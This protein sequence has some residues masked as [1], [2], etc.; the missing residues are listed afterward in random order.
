M[1]KPRP[2]TDLVLRSLLTIDV[3]KVTAWAFGGFADVRP[4]CGRWKLPDHDPR[5]VLGAR[6]AA[7]ENSLSVAL[8]DWRPSLIVMAEPFK[9]RNSAEMMNKGALTGIVEA[10][11]W[12]RDIDIRVQPEGTVR[13][14]MLGRGSGPTELMKALAIAWCNRNGIA[15]ADHNEADVCVLWRWARDDLVRQRK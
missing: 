1:V 15:V 7:L 6:V 2:S 10:E 12:R 14:E 8:D 3:G 13:K 4:R 9:S 5:T 11:A